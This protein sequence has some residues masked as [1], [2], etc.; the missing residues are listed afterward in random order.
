MPT[1]DYR[2]PAGHDF[3]NF[4][5]KISDSVSVLPC[6]ECGLQAD[7][8]V[9]GGA[10]LVFKGSGFYLTDYGKNA[11]RKAGVADSGKAEGSDAKGEKGKEGV[12]SESKDGASTE[13]KGG[14]SVE[15]KGGPSESR[16]ESKGESK[17]GGSKPGEA[18]PGSSGPDSAKPE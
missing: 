15:S 7:R 10:G 8:R 14:A 16:G 13:S 1:Y 18:K 4:V 17:V 3:T 11:H 6:P 9:S 5:R 12:A 2:C